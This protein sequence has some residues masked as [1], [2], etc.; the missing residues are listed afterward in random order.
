MSASP[1]VSPE[2]PPEVPRNSPRRPLLAFPGSPPRAPGPRGLGRRQGSREGYQRRPTL[3]R[4]NR[5]RSKRYAP[6]PIPAADPSAIRAGAPGGIS[7]DRRQNGVRRIWTIA[8]SASR[9]PIR[10]ETTGPTSGHRDLR[11]RVR[12]G[13]EAVA[14]LRNCHLE[15]HG[16]PNQARG[17][18]PNR[19]V[20]TVRRQLEI[21]SGDAT[22][23]DS[24]KDRE[25]S[26]G[27]VDSGCTI[28]EQ[29]SERTHRFAR[30]SFR[31]HRRG[32]TARF[33]SSSPDTARNPRQVG[34][35]ARQQGRRSSDSDDPDIC[36]EFVS[37]SSRVP[38]PVLVGPPT[39]PR[40]RQSAFTS[41]FPSLRP[42]PRAGG[43]SFPPTPQ[44]ADRSPSLDSTTIPA[45][46]FG[47]PRSRRAH[48]AVLNSWGPTA[49]PTAVVARLPASNLR[50]DLVASPPC[51]LAASPR[52]LPRCRVRSSVDGG[53]RPA[54]RAVGSSPASRGGGPGSTYPVARPPT[55][56]PP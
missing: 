2:F 8:M 28:E 13:P 23:D 30:I 42:R 26:L 17:S 53:L 11:C 15:A 39:R 14:T 56:S 48:P 4:L 3:R 25:N 36:Q 12:A 7:S 1:D 19:G 21:T 34:Q 50:C 52:R 22:P 6:A 41:P 32:P 24:I 5:S 43:F 35:Q 37:G 55:S 18:H 38:S 20:A 44:R 16:H 31:S 47:D 9:V 27:G 29:R 46:G 10:D 45:G 40:T 49:G 51:R 54:S 33:D